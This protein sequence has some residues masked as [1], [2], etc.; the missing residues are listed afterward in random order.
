MADFVCGYPPKVTISGQTVTIPKAEIDPVIAATFTASDYVAFVTGTPATFQLT[1]AGTQNADGSWTFTV[2]GDISGYVSGTDRATPKV[3]SSVSHYTTLATCTAAMANDGSDRALVWYSDTNDSFTWS[4]SV[5]DGITAGYNVSGCLPDAS[6]MFA[7]YRRWY[8]LAGD[9]STITTALTIENMS[10]CGYDLYTN[11]IRL[12]PTSAM[13][14][15]S[16]NRCRFY[17]EQAPLLIQ[18]G[19]TANTVTV[20]SCVF[21]GCISAIYAET[22]LAYNNC[23]VVASGNYISGATVTATNCLFIHPRTAVSGGGT[24]SPTTCM[25]TDGSIG[26]QKTMAQLETWH[27]ESYTGAPDEYSP[28]AST[29]DLLGAGT[30]S[31][32]THDSHGQAFSAGSYPVGASLLFKVRDPNEV[33]KSAG[34]NWDDDNLT[35]QT[36]FTANVKVDIVGGLSWTGGYDP[37]G[38]AP[39]AANLNI[40]DNADGTGAV[41]TISGGDAGATYTVYTTRSGTRDWTSSG[42]RV[43]NGNVSLSLVNGEYIAVVIGG[44]VAM[45]VG[46]AAFFWV[47]AGSLFRTRTR[48]RVA[49]SLLRAISGN[50][51]S[52]ARGIQVTYSSPG[53]DA[54]TVWAMDMDE[55]Q[56]GMVRPGTLTDEYRVRLLVPRQTGFPPSEFK[57][58]TQVTVEGTIYQVEDFDGSIQYSPSFVLT[59][60]RQGDTPDY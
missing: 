47:S 52:R 34:G 10:F 21:V 2:T 25:S 12:S 54:V 11:A 35:D 24:L 51:T 32:A 26:T 57:W 44:T 55:G 7:Y 38:T 1:G 5:G 40:V 23:T 31:A 4:E 6:V 18:S 53:A 42:S 60:G 20:N 29:S 36:D 58:G 37:T 13:V 16:V 9:L 41:A 56:T 30:D 49:Q 8:R 3:G 28:A 33:I 50:G 39:T 43:G 17:S 45:S 14:G 48:S 27:T 22:A 15:L 46:Q 59:C 19:Q